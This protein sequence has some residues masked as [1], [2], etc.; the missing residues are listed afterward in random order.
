M[1]LKTKSIKLALIPPLVAVCVVT[2]YALIGIPNVKVMDFIL[3]V[4]GLYFGCWVGASVGMLS[5]AI[6]GVINPYGFIPQIWLTT[7]I[8][9][10]A[11]GVIGG[12][13]GKKLDI[14]NF[15]NRKL[16]L[17]ILF[18]SIGFLVTLAYDIITNVVYAYTFNIPILVA[19]IVGVPFTVLHEVSN[20][21]IFGFCFVPL[22]SALRR[23]I[24]GENFGILNK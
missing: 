20:L 1:E 17:G 18:G 2:N 8:C 3:F 21:A 6:Y 11:Y 23:L 7:M 14:N 22:N 24:G 19:I 16:Q 9:E 4:A 15:T 13:L 5:W 12:L 10:S